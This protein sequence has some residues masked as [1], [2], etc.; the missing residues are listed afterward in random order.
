MAHTVADL[1]REATADWA[2]AAD[3]GRGEAAKADAFTAATAALAC[4]GTVST[5]LAL[6][7]CPMVVAYRIG[8][9]QLRV[10]KRLMTD[11]S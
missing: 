7:G 5:E 6:A 10:L 2:T 1:V 9:G 8:R 3:P 4:S 11:R